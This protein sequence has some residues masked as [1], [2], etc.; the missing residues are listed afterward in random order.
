MKLMIKNP[1]RHDDTKQNDKFMILW[2]KMITANN[3][4]NETPIPAAVWYDAD[5]II[6]ENERD[7]TNNNKNKNIVRK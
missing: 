3:A 6:T 7:T 4:K 1:I 2:K 5:P